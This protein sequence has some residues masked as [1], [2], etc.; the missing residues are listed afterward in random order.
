[1]KRLVCAVLAIV[2]SASVMAQDAGIQ[3]YVEVI[4]VA[5]VSFMP[6]QFEM[7]IEIDEAVMKSKSSVAKVESEMVAKL[8]RLGMDTDEVLKM[9]D[10]SMISKSRR[11]S[12]TKASYILELDSVEMV[13]EVMDA[14]AQIETKSVKLSKMTN[15][16]MDRYRLEA[17]SKALLNAKEQAQNYAEVIGQSVGECFRVSG[18]LNTPRSATGVVMVGYSAANATPQRENIEIKEITI[19]ASVTARFIL[20]LKDE[21][22]KQVIR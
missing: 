2:V 14:L 11:S 20:N 17:S 7:E 19:E 5:K 21:A 1:M 9:D 13:V 3:N 15:T 10:M 4:G 12:R 16:E 18:H 8:K 22:I 6:D